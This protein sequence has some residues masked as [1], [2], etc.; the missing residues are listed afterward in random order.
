MAVEITRRDHSLIR[1]DTRLAEASELAREP[2]VWRWSH[3]QN[4]TAGL[5]YVRSDPNEGDRTS[6]ARGRL[7]S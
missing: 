5:S 7:R 3:T 4:H 6:W 2:M 1:V